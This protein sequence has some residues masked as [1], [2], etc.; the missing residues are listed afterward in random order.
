MLNFAG[1]YFLFL[2]LN[3]DSSQSNINNSSYLND[4][5]LVATFY[6]MMAEKVAIL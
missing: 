1:L 6:C 2:Q 4:N 3:V 5:K